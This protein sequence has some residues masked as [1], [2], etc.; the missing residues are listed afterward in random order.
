MLNRVTSRSSLRTRGAG[1]SAHQQARPGGRSIMVVSRRKVR[2]FV[3]R[4][5]L[6]LQENGRPSLKGIPARRDHSQGLVRWAEEPRAARL[7]KGAS[8]VKRHPVAARVGPRQVN[9]R[10]HERLASPSAPSCG[11]P[12]LGFGATPR[13]SVRAERRGHAHRTH[14]PVSI[15]RRRCPLSDRN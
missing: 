5:K 3:L 11:A 4:T 13:S 7:R 9:R 15:Q 12:H 1:P 2:S 6:G 10:W 14:R 8:D